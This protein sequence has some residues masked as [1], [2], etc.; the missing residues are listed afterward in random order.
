MNPDD[1]TQQHIRRSVGLRA[2]RQIRGIVDEENA[3]D[4]F[5]VR[6]VR[7]LIIGLLLVIAL[8]LPCFIAYRLGVI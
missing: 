3:D 7:Y 1:I 4:A 5:K 8:I 2:L 6:A